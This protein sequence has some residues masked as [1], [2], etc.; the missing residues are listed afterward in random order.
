DLVGRMIAQGAGEVG[1]DVG[2]NLEIRAGQHG[3]LS[4][5]V[6]GAA[7]GG[8]AVADPE[9]AGGVEGDPG[10]EASAAFVVGDG[11]DVL[12]GGERA[13]G[14]DAEALDQALIGRGV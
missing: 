7:G 8:V 1:D 10:D 5:P 2:V 3:D 4:R 6:G 9:G 12:C 14:V 13:V 11:R